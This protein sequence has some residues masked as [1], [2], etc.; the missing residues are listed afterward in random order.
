MPDDTRLRHDWP[1]EPDP[2]S[3]LTVVLWAVGFGWIV[4]FLMGM[5]AG[6]ALMRYLG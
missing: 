4:G 2:V 3:P 6:V 5:G 1:E